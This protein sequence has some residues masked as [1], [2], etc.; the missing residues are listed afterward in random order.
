MNFKALARTFVV[1]ALYFCVLSWYYG[2][3]LPLWSVAIAAGVGL[4]AGY[5]F[6][7]TK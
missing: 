1:L 7:R 2:V 3:S 4:F 5:V 6:R